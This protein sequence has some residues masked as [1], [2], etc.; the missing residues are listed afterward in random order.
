LE[1]T[2]GRKEDGKPAA[3]GAIREK[4]EAEK[5]PWVWPVFY[6]RI[7]VS[8]S[9]L[10]GTSLGSGKRKRTLLPPERKERKWRPQKNRSIYPLSESRAPVSNSFHIRLSLGAERDHCRLRSNRRRKGGR[11]QPFSPAGVKDGRE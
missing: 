1:Y 2:W 4:G 6:P 3:S 10:F 8:S 9:F 11:I 5:K 7:Q